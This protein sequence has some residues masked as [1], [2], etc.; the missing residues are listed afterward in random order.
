MVK[1]LLPGL[2][3]LSVCFMF[4]L[5]FAQES[6]PLTPNA[7]SLPVD[8]VLPYPGILPDHPLYFLK[9]IRDRILTFLITNPVRKVEFHILMADKQL[10]MGIFLREKGKTE[11]AVSAVERGVG[12]LKQAEEYLFEVPAGDTHIGSLKDR[13]EKALMKQKEVITQM[14]TVV[15]EDEKEQL[16]T[17]LQELELLSQDY[18]RRK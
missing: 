5:A 9:V 17:T 7:S 15:N 11:L 3:L 14:Q 13:W 2:A 18:S 10:N 16:T 4:P 6:T 1:V 12:H 8:Y